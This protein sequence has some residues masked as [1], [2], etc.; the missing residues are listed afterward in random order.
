VTNPQDVNKTL[1]KRSDSCRHKSQSSKV[2]S[3]SSKFN[4]TSG[5]KRLPFDKTTLRTRVIPLLRRLNEGDYPAKAGKSIGLSRSNTQYYIKNL[6]SLGLIYREKRSNITIYVLTER[7]SNFLRSCEGNVFPSEF[8]RL[9][10]CQ[11]SFGILQEGRYPDEEFRKVEMINWTALLGVE[12]G[13][14]VRHTS[15]SWIV[16]IPVI[17]GKHPAELHGKA[18]N[19]ANRIAIALTQ[20]YGVVLADPEFVGSGGET[21][22]Y[23]PV[24]KLLGRDNTINVGDRKIDHS[25]GEG[26]LEHTKRDAVIAYLQMPE[27]V[28]DANEKIDRL[29]LRFERLESKVDGLATANER[30][31]DSVDKIATFCSSNL[32]SLGVSGTKDEQSSNRGS[33]SIGGQSYVY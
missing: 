5:F 28:K 4:L 32:S 1:A 10:K 20:K 14:T 16:H 2:V 22:V 21:V 31:V 26:E 24:A 11:V 3:Q 8:Y 17:H 15:R 25:W 18:L 7:C 30:L 12:Q 33:S 9:D 13:V 6:V 27:G 23:D 19:L 29:G